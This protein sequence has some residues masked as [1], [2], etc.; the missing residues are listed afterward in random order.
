MKKACLLNC[1]KTSENKKQIENYL[2]GYS[3]NK[4]LL[5]LD[6][7]ERDYFG[8]NAETDIEY[9][10]EVPLARARMFEVRHFVMS[11]ENSEE[12]LLLYYHYIRGEPVERCAELLG[13]SRASA[14]R[15]KNRALILAASKARDTG[16]FQSAGELTNST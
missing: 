3:F 5:R 16:I 10:G 12:K 14:F 6:R 4:K 11:L 9:Y 1:E 2:K 13:V 15:M 8:R 7:Y